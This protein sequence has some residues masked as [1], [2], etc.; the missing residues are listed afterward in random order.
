MRKRM[1]TVLV[2]LT[3]ACPASGLAY[4]PFTTDDA[5]VVGKGAMQSELSWDQVRQHQGDETNAV[6]YTLLYG[7]FERV[8]LSVGLPYMWE[9]P[10]HGANANGIGDITLAAKW[11]LRDET[12]AFPACALKGLL[13]TE[14]GDAQDGLGSGATDYE[15]F[16]LVSKELGAVIAHGAFGYGL[17]GDY[18]NVRKRNIYLYGVAL[19]YGLAAG[20]HLGAEISG[21]RNPARGTSKDPTVAL[22]AVRYEVSETL[23]LDSALRFGLNR[24]APELQWS[25]GLSLAY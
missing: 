13:K 10:H 2:V 18:G 22:I 1:Y 9:A 15:V 24:A 11:L 23:I 4:R 20:W 16:G 19:D 25:L 12:P 21:N 6:L 5:G 7:P 3:V 14:S 17:I 8:E